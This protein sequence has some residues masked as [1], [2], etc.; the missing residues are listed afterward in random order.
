MTGRTTDLTY[1]KSISDND[2]QFIREM[3]DTFLE[4][5]PVL[6]SQMRSLAHKKQWAELGK[7]AHQMKPSL[8]FMGMEPTRL[9]IREIEEICAGKPEYPEV[10]KLVEKTESACKKACVELKNLLDNEILSSR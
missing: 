8:Q 7:T 6:L 5:T 1:L 2:Q 9:I 3:I 4:T 10:I